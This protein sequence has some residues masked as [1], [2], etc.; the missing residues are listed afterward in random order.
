M[1][2]VMGRFQISEV[3]NRSKCLT[4]PDT[5]SL[6]SFEF[7]TMLSFQSLFTDTM[8]YFSSFDQFSI[9]SA[10]HFH[11]LTNFIDFWLNNNDFQRLSLS[12]GE[13]WFLSVILN[14]P[15]HVTW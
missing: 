4:L 14:A 8:D 6:F 3:L 1:A 15:S 5:F 13:F 2:A 12:T 10:V 11:F 7:V 9:A